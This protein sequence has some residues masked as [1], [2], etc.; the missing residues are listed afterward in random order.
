MM[1]LT[2]PP[3]SF[4]IAPAIFLNLLEHSHFIQVLHT[5]DAIIIE[6]QFSKL[7]ARFETGFNSNKQVLAQDE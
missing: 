1:A 6:I 7:L 4:S 3:L 5:G 2:P